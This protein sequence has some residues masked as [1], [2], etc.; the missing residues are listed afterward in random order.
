MTATTGNYAATHARAYATLTKKGA[1]ITFTKAGVTV[2]GSAVEDAGD[3]QAYGA[4][5]LI[6]RDPHTLI[7]CLTTY[8]DVVPQGALCWWAGTRYTVE[9]KY[10]TAPDGVP[11]ITKVVVAV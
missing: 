6:E 5:N 3:P 2:A 1:P 7:V 11:V 9:K 4:M 8:G 10:P